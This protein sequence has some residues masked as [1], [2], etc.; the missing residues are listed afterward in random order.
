MTIQSLEIDESN[1]NTKRMLDLMAVNQDDGSM[2]LYL[3]K[4]TQILKSLRLIQQ[5]T[6]GPFNYAE[7]KAEVENSDLTPFQKTPLS[8]RLDSLESFMPKWQTEMNPRKKGRKGRVGGND[9]TVKVCELPSLK[10]IT[11]LIQPVA[12]TSYDSR[13]FVPM[14]NI[15]KRLL[16]IQH[17][18]KSLSGAKY[19]SW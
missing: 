19:R 18:S 8:Q 17:V 6:D 5:Q 4:I 16:T 7:F 3:H 9:W 10:A 1:L 2:P 15:R 13:P 11:F 12:R 14:R